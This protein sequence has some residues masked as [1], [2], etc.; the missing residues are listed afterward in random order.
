[1]H[2]HQ[3]S[4]GYYAQ[5][6]IWLPFTILH[7]CIFRPIQYI[8][9]RLLRPDKHKL[10]ELCFIAIATRKQNHFSRTTLWAYIPYV[11]DTS[12]Y[13]AMQPLAK[14][15]IVF[16]LLEGRECSKRMPISPIDGITVCLRQGLE[17][18]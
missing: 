8:V 5:R 15:R 13:I 14:Y 16:D 18:K 2:H 3:H 7:P 17:Q 10:K 4:R 12:T 6:F 11:Y 9:S 1:M